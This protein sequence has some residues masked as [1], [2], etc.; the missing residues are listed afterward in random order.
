MTGLE[1]DVQLITQE[2]VDDIPQTVDDILQTVDDIP[3]AVDDILQTVDDIPQAVMVSI[4]VCKAP[5]C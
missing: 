5:K 1:D 2:T 4:W 3:Q